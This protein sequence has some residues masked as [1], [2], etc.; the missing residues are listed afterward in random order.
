MA[1]VLDAV[2]AWYNIRWY[3]PAYSD[4]ALTKNG[5]G[6]QPRKSKMK[7]DYDYLFFYF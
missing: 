6:T 1:K 7:A 2:S 5:A 3:G 4:L